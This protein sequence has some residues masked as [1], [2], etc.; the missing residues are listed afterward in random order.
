MNEAIDIATQEINWHESHNV[1][2]GYPGDEYKQGFINGLYHL[3]NLFKA[4][5][6][7]SQQKDLS[8]PEPCTHPVGYIKSVRICGLC[9]EQRSGYGGDYIA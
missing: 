1:G 9:G 2:D 8:D 3:R 6:A 4:V 5:E 7:A